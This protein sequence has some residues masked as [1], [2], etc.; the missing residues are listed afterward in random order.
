[1]MYLFLNLLTSLVVLTGANRT[2]PLYIAGLFP[3]SEE[4]GWSRFFGFASLKASERAIVDI[5]NSSDVLPNYEVVMIYSDTEGNKV[6]ALNKLYDHIYTPPVKVALMG[7]VLSSVTESVGEV[8]G[9]WNLVEISP[10]G[11]SP[12]LSDRARYPYIYRVLTSAAGFSHAEMGIIRRFGWT[13]IATLHETVEPHVGTTVEMQKL[14]EQN[15]VTVIAAE[16]FLANPF[17]AIQRLKDKDAR[18]IAAN[19]YEGRVRKVFCSAYRLGLYGS[20]YVWMIPG[21]FKNGWWKVAEE[22]VSCTPD[23]LKIASEGYLTIMWSQ[24]GREEVNTIAGITPAEYRRQ[25]EPVV[26]YSIPVTGRGLTANAYDGMWS[27]ALGLHDAEKELNRSLDTFHYEDKEF[28]DVVSRCVQR[29]KFPGVSGPFGYSELGDRVGTLLIEQNINGSEE[30]IGT[31]DKDNNSV[32]WLISTR[33]IW[34]YAGGKAPFDYDITQTITQLESTPIA[35]L[36]TVCVLCCLGTIIAICF[37]VFNIWKRQNRQVKMSSPKVNNLISIGIILA[38]LCVIL[39]GVDRSL[40]D[41]DTLRILCTVRSWG[42]ALAFTIAFGGMFT[43]MWRVY[44][45][46][47][48]NKTKRKVIKDHHLFIIIGILLLVDLAI[49][50]PWQIIDPIG[51]V[52]E[53]VLVPQTEEDFALYRRYV[54]LHVKCTSVNDTIWTMAIIIYKAFVVVF[55]AFLAWSTRNVNVPGLNDSYYVGLS[56]YNTVICCVVAVPLSILNVSSMGVTYAL[57]A[58]FLLLCTTMTLCMLF[59]P[60]IIAVFRKNAVAEQV[61]FTGNRVGSVNRPVGTDHGTDQPSQQALCSHPTDSQGNSSIH[62]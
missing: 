27:L 16:S 44:S 18:I 42:L 41:E 31:Y 26:G 60:K 24:Y 49:L 58:G 53:E 25:M 15:N 62:K 34:Y 21:Y 45:I 36:I 55:G 19:F 7:S 28:A 20:R 22:G 57:V 39:M 9:R 23:E 11:S 52:N 35:I 59:I 54:E 37:I 13:K 47:I 56:I 8:A 6:T 17:D 2:R 43:K 1:M 48:H 32:S 50:I 51:I 4:D 14:A 33:E 12:V 30:V 40:V 46:V 3:L 61:N 10:A 38:Y 5:N 29:Q